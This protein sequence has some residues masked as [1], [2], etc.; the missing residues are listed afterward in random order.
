MFT[1]VLG[2]ATL[3]A[4]ISALEQSGES[5]TLSAPRLTVLN[6]RPA[7]ISD[8]QVQ[9]YYE[10]FAVANTVQQY[11]TASAIYPS[12]KP[13][14]ITAGAELNVL[15]SV[16]GDG[17]SIVLALNPKV[18][19][20]VQLVPYNT[21]VQY[22]ANNTPQSSFQIKLPT[23][24]TDE[25]ATRVV[26]KS[27]ETVVMGGVLQEDKYTYV[28]SVPVLGDIP[29]VGAL[30]RRR[31]DSDSPRYLL[32]FVTATIVKDN[33]EFLVYDDE[34]SATNTPSVTR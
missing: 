21:I 11:Y 31:T 20:Q 24:R 30:F 12:G 15:A 3:S 14:R 32:V 16:S 25:L 5:H 8:G 18:N 4:T 7:T 34:H 28:E 2:A 9:Y 26:V 23:Y 19:T 29:I 13:T 10:E 27:G 22:N 1:N 6:N 17:K 33:G